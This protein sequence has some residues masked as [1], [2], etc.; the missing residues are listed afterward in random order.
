M[1][2]LKGY[3]GPMLI[4]SAPVERSRIFSHQ[5]VLPE[6]NISGEIL[7]SVAKYLLNEIF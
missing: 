7:L 3:S 6:Q 4:N 5:Y 1:L 2:Y